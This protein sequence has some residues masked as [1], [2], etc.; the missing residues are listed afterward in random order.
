MSTAY[1]ATKPILLAPAGSLTAAWA[2]LGAGAD[3]IYVGLE[4]F[5]RGGPRNE[6]ASQA[7]RDVLTAAHAQSRHVQVALNTIPRQ[8]ERR[9]LAEKVEEL[10]GWGI[11]GVIVN[12]AGL[13]AE[14]RS[15]YPRLGIT[16]SIG[17]AVMNE[18]DVAFYRDLGADA[19]V[20]PGTLTPDEIVAFTQVPDVQI[21]VMVHMVQEF[22]LLGRCWMPSYYRLHSTPLA[23]QCEDV[24]RLIGSVKRGGAGICFKLC[25]QPW[26]LYRSE[27]CVATR[28][29]PSRQISAINYL[30]DLLNAGVDVVKLQGRGLAADLLAPLVQRYRLAIDAWMAGEPLPAFAEPCL[31]PSWT[32]MRR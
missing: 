28:L 30:A 2:A 27:R 21:E 7:L 17:C 25:E 11:N 8:A 15:R 14:L 18:A 26:E 10:L 29:L 31:E 19:V 5:S 13:L 16:A 24:S 9:D 22:I 1:R 12:D 6:L 23:S 20:L 4:G 32:V 3:A